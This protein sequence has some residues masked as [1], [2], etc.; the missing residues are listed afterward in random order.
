MYMQG[1]LPRHT[2][3]T[4]CYGEEPKSTWSMDFAE[5]LLVNLLFPDDEII[6]WWWWWWDPPPDLIKKLE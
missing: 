2:V 6:K 5:K 1:Q 3:A 4:A